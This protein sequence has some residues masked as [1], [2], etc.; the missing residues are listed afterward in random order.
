VT[1]LL[2]GDSHVGLGLLNLLLGN[3][4]LERETLQRQQ[5]GEKKVTGKEKTPLLG[6]LN[7]SPKAWR[8]RETTASLQPADCSH[9]SLL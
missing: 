8:L 5:V 7:P 4:K 3:D 2:A 6:A 1:L 9:R